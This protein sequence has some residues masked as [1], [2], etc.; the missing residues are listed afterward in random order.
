MKVKIIDIGNKGFEDAYQYQLE[1]V[2]E[3][4]NKRNDIDLAGYFIYVEHPHVYTLGKHGNTGNLLISEQLLAK[5]NASFVKTDRG[6]DITYHGPGQIVGYPILDLMKLQM[7]PKHFVYNLEEVIIR[8]L[9]KYGIHGDRINGSIGVWLDIDK[10][11]PRKICSIGIRI[12]RNITMHGFALNVNNDLKYF[13]YI[14][15]CGFTNIAV[16]SMANELGHPVD[17]DEV[18][19]EILNNFRDIFDIQLSY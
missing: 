7:G 16:T 3:L 9:A 13:S 18:K 6:G 17:I 11:Q 8:V 19:N 4:V 15:P 5:I 14:N 1:K 2:D 12:T 10:P